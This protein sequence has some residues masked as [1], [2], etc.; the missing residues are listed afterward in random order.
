MV[1]SANVPTRAELVRRA[2]DLVPVLRANAAWT[3][4]NRRLHE[5]T[6]EALA[7]AGI[8]RMRAPA[9]YGGFESDAQTLVDVGTE[10]GRGDGSA[11]WVAS[12]YWIPGWMAGLFPDEVQDEVFST[13]DVRVCGTLSPAGTAIPQPGGGVVLNGQWGFISG[14]LHSHWQE[15]IA[16][17]IPE[18]GQ[19]E[20]IM[21]L[22]PIK[23]LEI[24]DDWHVSGLRGTGSVTTV[25]KDVFIPEERVLS[26]GAVL[27][28]QYASV[29]NADSPM[30]RAPLLGVANASAV[31][32]VLGL[33]KAA[34]EVFLERM[35]SR[36]LTYTSYESQREAPITHLRVADAA[37]TIDRAEFHARRVADLVDA[38]GATGEPWTLE[39]RAR[40]RADVGVVCK[41]AKDAIDALAMASG[42]SSIYHTVA[43]QRINRDIQA[44]N[45]HALMAPDANFELYGR[46]LCGLEP[47]SAYI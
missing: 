24:A 14:A 12:V 42:G 9:R 23:E 4:E 28:G 46:I 37:L 29:R 38:K 30:F 34:K 27:S 21:G 5:E 44:I 47:N 13:P 6:I 31:G 33:A 41:L 8:F 32:T 15:I 16:I 17:R 40:S 3:D 25:A 35:P 18:N 10:L 26:L 19:P 43:M 11:S 20:P 2:S 7:D 36:K 39:E 22:V 45:L 1:E